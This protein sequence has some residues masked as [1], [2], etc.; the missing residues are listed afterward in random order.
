MGALTGILL[1][2]AVTA[3]LI[4]FG[5]RRLVRAR[6]RRAACARAGAS[7]ERAI[8]IRSY[9]EMDGHLAGRWCHCGGYLERGGEGTRE[10][11]DRRYRVVQLR[12]QECE[13]PQ[14]AYFDVTD[15]LH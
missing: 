4:S 2:A 1:A 5:R 3:A 12:C 8:H 13:E 15:L 14:A 9:T 6:L 11:D 7:P 10:S